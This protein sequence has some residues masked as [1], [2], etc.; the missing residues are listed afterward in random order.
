[1]QARGP[2]MIEHRL[3]ETMI[4]VI[5]QRLQRAAQDGAIDPRFVDTA[6]DF[7]RV[8][9]DRTHHGKEEDILFRDLARKNMTEEHRR[10]MADLV[11]EHVF[12][13]ETTRSLVEANTRYRRGEAGALPDVLAHLRALAT[14]Y[15]GH[16]KKEDA[17]FF[18]A[19]L[20]YVT[21]EE[22]QAMLGEFR[23]F[24]WPDDPREVPGGGQGLQH[25]L[26]GRPSR[27]P[28]VACA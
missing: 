1:M 11:A 21:E 27:F 28:G 3:I 18:P 6:V 9:A 16:I 24:R 2:L 12:G 22:D 4:A 23:E 14:F 25:R 13:R 10:V 7:V 15:P 17:V 20:T 19:A 8:Y 26:T 5:N